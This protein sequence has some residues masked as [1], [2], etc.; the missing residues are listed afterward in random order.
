METQRAVL[1]LKVNVDGAFCLETGDAG[2]GVV[3]RDDAGQPLLMASRRIFHCRD[4]EEAEAL[5][6][7]EGVR[8]SSRCLDLGLF[9]GDQDACR[10][11]A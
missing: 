2:I 4:A 3:V 5:A 9:L 8:M 6:C 10:E 11:G 1:A 7:L